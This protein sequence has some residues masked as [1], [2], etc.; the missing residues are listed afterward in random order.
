MHSWAGWA[1]GHPERRRHPLRPRNPP[2]AGSRFS[3]LLDGFFFVFAGLAAIWLA[4]LLFTES[5]AFGWWGILGFVLFWALLAYLVLPRLHRIL[6]T[7]YVPDYFIGRART[8]DGLLG[9]PVNLA[10]LGDEPQLHAAMV[11]AGWT[12]ADEIT[13]A[14]QL[15]HH[16]VDRHPSQLRRG[17]RE[18]ALPLRPAAG[19]RVPA[20]GG[21][22]SREAP[23]RALLALPRRVAAARRLP[24]RLARRR[25]VRP[26]RGL[27]AL[28]AAGHA[29]DRRRHR[30]RARPHRGPRC[31]R[32]I[33]PSP[34]RCW[35]TSRRATTPA[36]AAATRS[37]P[38]ATC[39]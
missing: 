3:A 34:S 6:T 13:L 10:V 18:P 16:H 5:F 21:R 32:R 36:T 15:A 31:A 14:L 4:L 33:R 12:R 17:T 27:L 11:A 9:D 24:R 26:G 23:P 28:H 22:Q 7:I 20:G 8:S 2:R 30:R 39:R 25:H 29:Q 19:C 35:R 37:S 1:R 38:T